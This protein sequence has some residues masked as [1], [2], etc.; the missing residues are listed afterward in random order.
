MALGILSAV[1][2]GLALFVTRMAHSTAEARLL[3]TASELAAN[4]LESIKTSSDYASIDTFA[5]TE[6]FG[7]TSEYAG[8]TRV[9]QVSHIGGSVSDSVDYRIVTVTV[10]NPVMTSA[11]AQTTAIAAF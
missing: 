6:T 10:S 2:L 11:I 7:S 8:F 3:G 9:T 5:T 4:R 1:L